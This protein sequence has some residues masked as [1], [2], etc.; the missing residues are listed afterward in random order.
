[1]KTRLLR[2]IFGS[3]L[4][5]SADVA[6]AQDYPSRP[7]RLIHTGAPG[8]TNDVVARLVA[9]RM[10]ADL[11]QQFL[12]EARPQGAGI[13][14]TQSVTISP[15][16]GYTVMFT[17]T[18]TH[19]I[20]PAIYKTLPYDIFR[21]F[22]PVTVLA[23]VP[24]ALVVNKDVPANSIGELIALLKKEPGKYLFASSGKGTPGHL[25][26]ELFKMRAGVEGVHV[27]YR[28]AGPAIVDLLAGRVHILFDNPP[29]VLPHIQSGAVRALATTGG[30]RLEILPNLPTLVEVGI[31]GADL[32]SWYG[33]AMPK[34]APGRVI[35][36]LNA[37]AVI[38]VK[39][40]EVA[41][42]LTELG[43][44]LWGSS[45]AEM[46]EFMQRQLPKWRAVVEAAGVTPD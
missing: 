13:P 32:A 40:A 9:Q 33:L 15:P 36:R 22:D 23:T 43:A 31:S 20:S 3:L 1:M 12:V 24:F 26:A 18:G 41:R 8:A 5:C 34:G 44:V 10:A 6:V 4:M 16:D 7:I 14:A 29:S 11:G 27:P 46:T 30:A 39:D 38:A 45:P 2:A 37:A 17:N 42:R 25:A 19:S 21:D 35:E 28:G